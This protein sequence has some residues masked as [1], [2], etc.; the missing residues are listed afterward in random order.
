MN[1]GNSIDPT[2]SW[3]IPP[4]RFPQPAANA[5]AVPDTSLVNMVDV[6]YW[7]VTKALPPIP[8][9]NLITDSPA[10]VLT[11]PVNMVGTPQIIKTAAETQR[12][13]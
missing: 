8:A 4:P 2:K 10:A 9:T 13:P 3:D 12:A 7:Q 11:S 5:L 1:N 6:Q